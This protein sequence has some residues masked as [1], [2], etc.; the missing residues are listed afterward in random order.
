MFGFFGERGLG[1]ENLFSPFEKKVLSP[2]NI[3]L[4][5]KGSVT[6]QLIS[7]YIKNIAF[8]LIFI[9]FVGIIVPNDKYKKYISI[10][11]GFVLIILV[12]SPIKGVFN[13]EAINFPSMFKELN[14]AYAGQNVEISKENEK[15]LELRKKAIADNFL[16]QIRLS[17]EGLLGN[18]GVLLKDLTVDFNE[19]TGELYGLT[20]SALKKADNSA[21]PPEKTKKPFIRIEPVEIKPKASEQKAS[22]QNASEQNASEQN[23]ESEALNEID[24][25]QIKKV[26]KAISD[27]YNMSVDNIHIKYE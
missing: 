4:F 22:E 12:I 3:Y 23:T 9:S 27:F 5:A 20:I 26:K 7:S 14:E 17:L 24:E 1:G 6:I 16:A 2:N 18:E 25:A 15:Y 11:L 13:G 8:F 10:L 21:K 19:E